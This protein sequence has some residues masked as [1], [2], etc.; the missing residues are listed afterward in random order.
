MNV[1]S[2]RRHFVPLFPSKIGLS[3]LLRGN[4]C[5][6]DPLHFGNTQLTNINNFL[7]RLVVFEQR[8]CQF[9]QFSVL[10]KRKFRPFAA[11]TVASSKKY[12]LTHFQKLKSFHLLMTQD[13]SLGN[14]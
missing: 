5:K 8:A 4:V 3:S 10:V 7:L 11:L 9:T 14:V 6:T 2:W 12:I 13:T 1:E